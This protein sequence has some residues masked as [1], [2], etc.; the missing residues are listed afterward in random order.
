MSTFVIGG[1]GFI[2]LRVIPLLIARGERVTCMDI[3]PTAASSF[4]GLGDKVTVLR[5]DVTSFDDVIANMAAAKPARVLN[6]SYHIGSDLAP[7]VAMRL[8]VLGMDNCFEASRLFGVQHVVYASSLAV[9]G[10]QQRFGDRAVTEDDFRYGNVQYA[11]HKIFNEWQAQDYSEK[12]GMTITGVRPAN[13][14]GPDKVRGSVDHVNCITQPARGKPVSFPYKDAMRIPVHVD[15]IAEVFVR[16]VL[17][18]KP[19]HRIYNSGGHSISLGALADMVREFLPDAQI[20]FEKDTGGKEISG[21]YLIDNSRLVEE[22]G[23][24]YRPFRERVQQIINE[25]R[26]QEGLPLVRG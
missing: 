24:Q 3:N 4:A 14:T 13:V 11:M 1:A 15:D 20:S 9:S 12:Y 26:Q 17:A 16:V 5:G 6:L 19:K 2:G 22:F 7:H 10:Q 8:N 18:D 23:V 25:V 21:N